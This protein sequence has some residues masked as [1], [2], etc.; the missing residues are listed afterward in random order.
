[1]G[2]ASLSTVRSMAFS[3]LRQLTIVNQTVPIWL[4][5]ALGE[6]FPALRINVLVPPTISWQSDGFRYVKNLTFLQNR[7]PQLNLLSYSASMRAFVTKIGGKVGDARLS[8]PKPRSSAGPGPVTVLISNESEIPS[9]G[10]I[11]AAVALA[12]RRLGD[13]IDKVVYEAGSSQVGRI[14]ETF[15]G[16]AQEVPSLDQYMNDSGGGLFVLVGPYPDG[17]TDSVAL[18]ALEKGG[19][20]LVAKGTLPFTPQLE[21]WMCVDYW[22]QSDL[23]CDRLCELIRNYAAVQNLLMQ[24]SEG[25]AHV[26]NWTQAS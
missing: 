5:A 2:L 12:K 6:A 23:I 1:M 24:S 10:H 8:L 4:L 20:P 3:G 11:A 22:E 16:L 17:M 26:N 13:R 14:L 25:R 9:Q 18:L 19:L 21:R 15:G 7:Y